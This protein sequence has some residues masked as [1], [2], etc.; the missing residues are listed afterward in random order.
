MILSDSK[1][2]KASITMSESV[3]ARAGV[4]HWKSSVDGSSHEN[5]WYYHKILDMVALVQTV[6]QAL[7]RF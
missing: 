2:F 5:G 6:T 7:E 1:E 4:I 3:P